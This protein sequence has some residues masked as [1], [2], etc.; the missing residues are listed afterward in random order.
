MNSL[1]PVQP[2]REIAQSYPPINGEYAAR[3]GYGIVKDEATPSSTHTVASG[4]KNRYPSPITGFCLMAGPSFWFDQNMRWQRSAQSGQT[5]A[6]G[7]G[8]ALFTS[9]AGSRCGTTR[10]QNGG[11]GCR[12]KFGHG[13]LRSLRGSRPVVTQTSSAHSQG[14]QPVRWSQTL[15]TTACCLVGLSARAQVRS[16][17]TYWAARPQTRIPARAVNQTVVPET[18]RGGGFVLSNDSRHVR[19][20]NKRT[21]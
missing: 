7:A 4:S 5:F 20:N 2:W 16:A 14:R 13:R 9:V 12:S 11:K 3:I 17:T 10:P 18:F 19:A 21:V 8:I 15:P 6:R 1:V